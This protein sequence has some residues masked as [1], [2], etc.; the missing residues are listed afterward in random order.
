MLMR[1]MKFG[2]YAAAFLALLVA[3]FLYSNGMFG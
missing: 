2:G 1:N 3:L